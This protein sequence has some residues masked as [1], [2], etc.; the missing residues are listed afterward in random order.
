MVK[1]KYIV[2]VPWL[3]IIKK[4]TK[5]VLYSHI[6]L[7]SLQTSLVKESPEPSRT[8]Q[9]VPPASVNFAVKSLP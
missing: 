9:F 1:N 3:S 5:S 7:Y 2:L 8:E 6:K 4:R